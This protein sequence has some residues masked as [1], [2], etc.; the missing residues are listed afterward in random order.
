[1][2]RELSHSPAETQFS[3]LSPTRMLPAYRT[4]VL[5]T[6]VPCQNEV[7]SILIFHGVFRVEH[8]A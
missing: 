1:M 7:F 5:V 3:L 4:P 8:V 2:Y 6:E